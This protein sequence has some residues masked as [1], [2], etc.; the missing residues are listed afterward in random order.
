MTVVIWVAIGAIVAAGIGWVLRAIWRAML[1]VFRAG[2][3]G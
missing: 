1:E 3:Q 2:R